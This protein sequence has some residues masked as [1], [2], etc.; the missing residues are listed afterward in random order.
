MLFGIIGVGGFIAP[1]HIKA[2]YE[3][4]H[5]LDCAVDVHDSVGVLD[6]YYLDCEFFTSL[7]D[8]HQYILN[9]KDQEK[10]LDFL[11]ICTPNY[12]HFEHIEFALSHGINAICEKP[13]VLDPNELDEIKNLEKKYNR[14][15]FNIMQLRLHPNMLDLK[16]N[17]QAT[18]QNEPTKVYHISLTYL[19]LRGKWYFSSWKGNIDRSGGLAANIGIH[20][21]DMLLHIF[22]SVV[23]SVVHVHTAHCMGGLL[24]LEHAK[25]SWFLSVSPGSLGL[26]QDQAHR[27]L[28]LE[29]QE[30]DFSTGFEELHTKN[31]QQIINNE[32]LTLD[33]LRS[34]IELVDSIRH[35]KPS[36]PDTD[37]H[38]LC[39]KVLD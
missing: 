23:D 13:L 14:R 3:T 22:G 5:V 9:C 25:V 19:I 30:I 7:E 27:Y 17:I 12:L 33:D 34:A 29:G 26:R 4:G 39:H 28:V 2:I 21:F 24:T 36:E 20:F 18:L 8:L 38:P 1:R 10:F 35:A 15:V 31:Y 16:Q 37:C 6:Q 32:G 11:A